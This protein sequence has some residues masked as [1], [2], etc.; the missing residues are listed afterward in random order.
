MKAYQLLGVGNLQLRDVS[1]PELKTGWCVVKVKACGICSSD[2][3]RI[4]TKGTYHFPTVPGHEISGVVDRVFDDKHKDLVGKRVAVF[5]LIPCMRCEQCAEHA[6][7]MC[8]NYDYVGSRRD[9]GFAEY[10]A[11]P[12]WNLVLLSD[13]VSF[14]EGA[15]FEPLAVAV[16]A[17]KKS[18]LNSSDTLAVVGTGMIALSIA[19]Y[20]ACIM[21]CASVTVIGR[22]ETKRSIVEKI[23]GVEFLSE[24]PSSRAF[25]KVIEAV[26]SNASISTALSICAPGGTITLVGNPEKE[27]TFTQNDYWKVLRKQLTIK[28]SWN[29]SY[30]EDWVAVK[31]AFQCKRFK[32]EL[33]ATH[34]FEASDL[35]RGL[36]LMKNRLESFIRVITVW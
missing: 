30:P 19:M 28:G 31:E 14:I 29:S 4:F 9:G 26:G 13:E 32:P 16:H 6:Y 7:E 27:I 1:Y 36:D 33:F 21:Q 10:V 2:I 25:T 12:V 24:V 11:V 15:E 23:D 18:K 5:P 20:A 8:A 17:I 3:P 35:P 34:V 22:S